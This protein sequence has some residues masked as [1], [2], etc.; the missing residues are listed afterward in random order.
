[1]NQPRHIMTGGRRSRLETIRPLLP[2]LIPPLL[3]A[4]VFLADLPGG[5]WRT[6]LDVAW[7]THPVTLLPGFGLGLE[8]LS[9]RLPRW[10]AT[11][12][13]AALIGLLTWAWRGGTAGYGFFAGCAAFSLS[14]LIEIGRWFKPDR[15]P[16]LSDPVIAALVAPLVWRLLRLLPVQPV[17]PLPRHGPW[18]TRGRILLRF[19]LAA[20]GLGLAAGGAGVASTIEGLGYAPAQFVTLV[21]D[22]PEGREGF[23]GAVA[24]TIAW[25]FEHSGAAGWLKAASRIDR[26]DDPP[27]PDWVGARAAHDG[28]LPTGRL[29]SVNTVETL[30]QAIDTALP[31]DVILLQ[32]GTYRIKQSPIGI[33]RPGAADALIVMRAPRLGSVILES[34]LPEAIKIGVPHWRF[35]NLVLRGVC[36]DDTAC[37]NG[38]HIVGAARNVTLRNL[39]I[40]D[41]NA[42]IKINR[43]HGQFPDAGRIEHTSL[44]NTHP[45]RTAAPVTPIDLVSANDWVIEDNLI[46]DFVKLQGNAVS[47]GAFAKGGARGTIFA[48]N[49][50]LCEWRLR[51]GLKGQTIGLSFGGGGTAWGTRRDLGRSGYEHADGMMKDNLIAF[52]SD[53]GI[54]L[55]RAANSVLRHNTLIGTSGIDVRHPESMALIEANVVDGPIRARDDGL[56]RDSG[57]E[58]GSLR[59]MFLGRNPVRELFVDPGRFDLRWRRLPVLVDTGQG[60]DLCG[61]ER[62]GFTPPGAYR[63]FR[64]CGQGEKP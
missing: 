23:S 52:C 34:E 60:L 53:D 24:N 27:F 41:F 63:D 26:P 64:V 9:A 31:G 48:R 55:N 57:N 28:V 25:T 15:L 44:I 16:D 35:E 5:G 29:R 32:P 42:Q 61:A 49:V 58:A 36:A 50:I 40:E 21:E 46:A 56:F 3:I 20:A 12:A 6:P 30:R 11:A 47:Y 14:L 7:S 10:L 2:W 33:A 19:A 43:E 39:R 51:G 17:T 59:G 18:R 1:M 45:R 22:L 13:L 38:F 37:D 54:Y 4:A 62:N 8:P